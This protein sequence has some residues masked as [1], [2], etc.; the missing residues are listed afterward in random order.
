[1]NNIAKIDLRR[2]NH[3]KLKELSEELKLD[4]NILARSKD[5]DYAMIWIDTNAGIVIAYTT[6]KDS[7]IRYSS[8]FLSILHSVKEVEVIKKP[9][10]FTLD[11]ILEKIS[12]YGIESLS[13]DELVLLNRFSK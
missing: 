13:V 10:A 5:G 7:S 1:M 6:K 4:Y 12:K 11:D 3:E 2:F 9:R 8:D